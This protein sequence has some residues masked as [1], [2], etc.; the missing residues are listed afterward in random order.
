MNII[1]Y[2]LCTEL[3]F[4]QLNKNKVEEITIFFTRITRPVA[5][6]IVR[7]FRDCS[8]AKA[9]PDNIIISK[10]ATS[11]LLTQKNFIN[12]VDIPQS[13]N[14]LYIV[15]FKCTKKDSVTYNKY[16]KSLYD[17]R[18]TSDIDDDDDYI[19]II[20]ITD[21]HGFEK[22]TDANRGAYDLY[23][24]SVIRQFSESVEYDYRTQIL[25]GIRSPHRRIR[26]EDENKQLFQFQP[27]ELRSPKDA[28]RFDTVKN[29]PGQCY[30]IV[31]LNA[32]GACSVR[33]IISI[34]INIG[35]KYDCTLFPP[36][37]QG[38]KVESLLDT[39]IRPLLPSTYFVNLTTTTTTPTFKVKLIHLLC[40]L[41]ST[42][43][44]G[45][46]NGIYVLDFV[47]GIL[48]VRSTHKISTT[49]T[50]MT[51]HELCIKSQEFGLVRFTST[52]S[53]IFDQETSA[54]IYATPNLINFIPTAPA[55][56]AQVFYPKI[57]TLRPPFH[58]NDTDNDIVCLNITRWMEAFIE[59]LC[60]S[61]SDVTDGFALVDDHNPISLEAAT[62]LGYLRKNDNQLML[63]IVP[64]NKDI[65][66]SDVVSRAV[67]VPFQK[68][69]AN[70]IAG[71]EITLGFICYIMGKMFGF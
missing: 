49:S 30:T 51:A 63:Y 19:K 17:S 61:L 60:H 41:L 26:R 12:D 27:D 53:S 21:P 4:I 56:F 52:M 65:I 40:T 39:L 54:Y 55:Y 28:I 24:G 25:P 35:Y 45:D 46:V 44:G 57:A 9:S 32:P 3:C 8:L 33:Y 2:E 22:L 71:Q 66:T 7:N 5:I 62:Q 15:C 29:I 70:C 20:R 43:F 36:I 58:R 34:C 13:D 69:I 42:V 31:N 10:V 64:T 37:L 14:C 18:G 23:T 59:L 38:C 16:I 47:N 11:N 50:P 67:S 48:L 68:V 6:D 1:P